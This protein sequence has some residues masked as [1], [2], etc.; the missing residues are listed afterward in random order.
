MLWCRQAANHF[1]NQSRYRLLSNAVLSMKR[2]KQLTKE[3]PSHRFLISSAAQA[4]SI[5]YMQNCMLLYSSIKLLYG[6]YWYPIYHWRP[7]IHCVTIQ[8]DSWEVEFFCAHAK[9]SSKKL[10][11]GANR[12]GSNSLF[13]TMKYCALCRHPLKRKLFSI[14]RKSPLAAPKFTKMTASGTAMRIS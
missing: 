13:Y 6:Y 4:L 12:I 8:S 7:L 14:R 2:W 10:C 1:V 11:C 3:K 9:V 5:S